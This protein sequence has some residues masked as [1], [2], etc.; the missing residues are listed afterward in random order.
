MKVYE[1]LPNVAEIIPNVP[2]MCLPVSE[3]MWKLVIANLKCN[4]KW[5]K[6]I[7]IEILINV[8]WTNNTKITYY[9]LHPERGEKGEV[10][11]YEIYISQSGKE[12]AYP[13]YFLKAV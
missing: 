9:E 4:I 5:A 6:I 1:I 11:F 3:E 12:T 8:G 10:L 7:G 13:S 2:P